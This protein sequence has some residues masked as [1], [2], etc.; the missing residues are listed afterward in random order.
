MSNKC[1]YSEVVLTREDGANAVGDTFRTAVSNVPLVGGLVAGLVPDT[2]TANVLR[3][4]PGKVVDHRSGY[5]PEMILLVVGG[6][7]LGAWAFFKFSKR[8]K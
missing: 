2:F 5:W 6:L 3:A 4:C 8:K 7:F 1:Q